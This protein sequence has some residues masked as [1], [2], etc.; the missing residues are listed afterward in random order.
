MSSFLTDRQQRVRVNGCLS[1][2]K[3]P[4]SGIPQGTVLGPVLFLVY[5][6]DLPCSISSD[7]SIFADDTSVYNT[8]SK[9]PS[10][11]SMLSKDLNYAAD[12]AAEWG[13]L[14]NAEKSEHLAISTRK[15]DITSPHVTMNG[16]Q[17]PQVTSHKHLGVN[18]NNT[19]SWQ[20]HVDK[21]YTS[22]ARRIGMIRRLRRKLHPVV[23]KR[24]YL[25]AVLP[26]LEYACPVWC[27]GPTQ[28]LIKMHANFCRR[29][30]SGTALPS[31]QTRFDY[32]TLVMFYKIHTKQAPSYL[33][34]LLPPLSSRSG[35]TFRNFLTVS[36]LYQ[37]PQLST[38]SYLEQL[39][40]GM[41]YLLMFNKQA[42][43]ILFKKLLQSHLKI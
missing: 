11:C 4:K 28:K 15:P 36:Q 10:I 21:V 5:I 23:L 7:C 33:T 29:N 22:C 8:G 31:L 26:K 14:F 37:E 35:Y 38:V 9:P 1:T 27:G 17:I 12:W 41:P 16:T 18:F 24:I 6:N 40:C 13:M 39:L 3:S 30:H 32:H 43:S 20:Q 42:Q 25:G 2:S 19:L 34:S